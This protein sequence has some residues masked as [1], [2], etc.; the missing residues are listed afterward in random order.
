MAQLP[1]WFR[2]TPCIN[3]PFGDC[4]CAMYF[5]HGV[6]I[7]GLLNGQNCQ[8]RLITP[9]NMSSENQWLEDVFPTEIAP[10]QGTC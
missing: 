10:F 7:L 3:L 6:S 1:Y 4:D 2:Q 8:Q 5:D 9:P